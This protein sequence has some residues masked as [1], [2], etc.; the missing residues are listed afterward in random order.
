[1]K[2]LQTVAAFDF[3]G[4]LTYSDT[5]LPFLFYAKGF[6]ATIFNLTRNLPALA[7]FALGIVPRQTAKEAV[8]TTFFA[9]TPLAEINALGAAFARSTLKKKICPEALKKLQWHQQQ[10]HRCILISASLDVYLAPWAQEVGIHDI[11]TSSLAV[12]ASGNATGRLLGDNCWGPEK[13]RRLT[14]LLGPREGYV[15]YAYGDS[16]G[17]REMLDHA[18]Y[19]F[20]RKYLPEPT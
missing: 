16:R 1:M 8:L 19:S 18:D 6:F 17:D 15:L 2:N 3:D 5:L 11:I 4:T 12:D 7:G 10:G 14:A 9:G 13:L 20:Y